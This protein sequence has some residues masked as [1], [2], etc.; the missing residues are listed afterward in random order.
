[1]RLGTWPTKIAKG[2]VAEKIYGDAEVLERH[3][4]RYE[5]NI[6]YVSKWVRR[7]SPFRELHRTERSLN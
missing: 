7:A 1:M 6:K 5:F 2:T 4:H 3:R